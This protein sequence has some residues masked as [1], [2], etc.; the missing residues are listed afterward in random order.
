LDK[1]DSG[2]VHSNLMADFEFVKL[3]EVEAI[4]KGI[5]EFLS[6]LSTFIVRFG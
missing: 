2:D 1:S 4:L 6:I 3:G 5:E